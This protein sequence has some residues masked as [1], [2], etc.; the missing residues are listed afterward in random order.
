M[1]LKLWWDPISQPSRTVKY[2]LLR[3]GADDYEE[4]QIKIIQDTRTDDYKKNV[5]PAGTVPVIHHD[6]LRLTESASELRYILDL[7]E[8]DETLLPRSD[9]KARSRVDYWLDWNGT[10]GRPAFTTALMKLK[11][12]PKAFG[13]PEP[14]E[15]E[16]KELH[17]K[18]NSSLAHIESSLGSKKYLTGAHLSI[19]DVQV[20][21]EI[22]ESKTIVEFSLDDYPKVAAWVARIEEDEHIKSLN[23]LFLQRLQE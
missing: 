12:L 1:S 9:L 14:T 16:A 5:N 7:Y 18:V 15:E 10:T 17:D 20:Y 4:N 23:E 11:F 22:F 2:A 6:D 8:G 21:N 13:A 3:V 19:G